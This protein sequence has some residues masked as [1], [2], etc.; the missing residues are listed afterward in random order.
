[1]VNAASLMTGGGGGGV[2]AAPAAAGG[3]PAAGGAEEKKEEKK[4]ESEEEEDE[5]SFSQC[6][7]VEMLLCYCSI[8]AIRSA[9]TQWRENDERHYNMHNLSPFH[10]EALLKLM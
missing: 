7:H 2:A 6:Y 10:L 9:G 4:E 8:V 3:A 1:M 5:V